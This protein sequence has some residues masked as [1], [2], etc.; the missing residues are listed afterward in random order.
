MTSQSAGAADST[1]GDPVQRFIGP[2]ASPRPIRHPSP[3]MSARSK[4]HSG[5]EPDPVAILRPGRNE[6]ANG[7]H[8]FTPPVRSNSARS[9]SCRSVRC[10]PASAS[11]RGRMMASQAS[12]ISAMVREPLQPARQPGARIADIIDDFGRVFAQDRGD[13]ANIDFQIASVSLAVAAEQLSRLQARIRGGEPG[14][15]GTELTQSSRIAAT[16]DFEGRKCTY[17]GLLSE[18]SPRLHGLWR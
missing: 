4:Q 11:R 9:R 18:S 17:K 5:Q 8:R 16:L 13:A 6:A 12:A 2:S 15:L 3:C 1:F 7:R 10:R 14:R